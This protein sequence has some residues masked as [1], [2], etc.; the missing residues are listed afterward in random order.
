MHHYT[1]LI[2]ITD[3]LLIHITTPY[4]YTSATHYR[5]TS[6]HLTDKHNRRLTD[7]HHRRL[8]DIHHRHLTD[9]NHWHLTDIHH[10]Y[11]SPTPYRHTSPTPYRYKS[12]V[13]QYL[14]ISYQYI[15]PKLLPPWRDRELW[16]INRHFAGFCY[17]LSKASNSRLTIYGNIHKSQSHF[18]SNLSFN[19]W[20]FSSSA[21]SFSTPF[22][23]RQNQQKREFKFPIPPVR[24]VFFQVLKIFSSRLQFTC[25]NREH[26][27][28][29][30]HR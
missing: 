7:I 28:K 26:L 6:L 12:P 20:R 29:S 3:A 16:L 18:L 2:N 25:F 30:R 21:W 13:H 22:Y 5:Y 24:K 10:R 11:T 19:A 9:I 1:L 8:T 15:S 4:R 23:R 27:R 14:P 17:F